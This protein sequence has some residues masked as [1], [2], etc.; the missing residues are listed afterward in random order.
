MMAL[1]EAGA[2][3]VFVIRGPTKPNTDSSGRKFVPQ[4]TELTVSERGRFRDDGCT[5]DRLRPQTESVRGP[6]V[7]AGRGGHGA[8][9]V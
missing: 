9:R 3:R 6:P 8:L 5:A 4:H 2:G 7:G 1:H